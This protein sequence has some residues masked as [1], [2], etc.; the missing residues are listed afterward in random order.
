[1]P[2]INI[3]AS[4]EAAAVEILTERPV[5][6]LDDEAWDNFVSALDSPVELDPAVKARYMGPS[7]WDNQNHRSCSPPA[8]ASRD[9]PWAS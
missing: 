6:A 4:R 5:I 9:S 7:Q 3:R 2:Q 1:M 8:T